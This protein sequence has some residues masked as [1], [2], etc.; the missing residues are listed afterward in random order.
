MKILDTER[1]TLRTLETDDAPFYLELV[2]DPAFLLYIGDKGVRTLEDARRAIAEGPQA[3]QR[4][5]G[6]SLYLVQRR[7]DGAPLG[8]CGLIKRDS[9]PEVDIGYALMPAYWGQGYAHEAA[10]GVVAHGR[11]SVGLKC[12]MAITSPENESSIGLLL[13]LG[14]RFVEFTHLPPDQRPTNIYRMEFSPTQP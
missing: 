4:E 11:D 2:N 8:M 5:R 9:L 1:L 12:L 7:S 14:L 6:H 13:K 10:A 3:M